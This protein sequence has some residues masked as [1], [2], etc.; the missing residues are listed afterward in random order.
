MRLR[1]RRSAKKSFH[2][3]AFESG[4]WEALDAEGEVDAV[5]TA[6]RLRGA[7]RCVK[8]GVCVCWGSLLGRVL[9][10]KEAVIVQGARIE[11]GYRFAKARA[12][13]RALL[14]SMVVVV[15]MGMVWWVWVWVNFTELHGAKL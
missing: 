3:S 9:V 6:D 8:A 14:A 5:R 10:V 11:G 7:R 4:V 13:Q 12:G 15:R 2:V 1:V